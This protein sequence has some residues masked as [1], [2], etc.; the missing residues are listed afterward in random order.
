[1]IQ[2]KFDSKINNIFHFK[3]ISMKHLFFFLVLLIGICGFKTVPSTV[4]MPS[5]K[6]YIATV[7]MKVSELTLLHSE[8]EITSDESYTE[9]KALSDANLKQACNTPSNG[10]LVTIKKGTTILYQGNTR[11]YEMKRRG[12]LDF[13]VNCD[14][15]APNSFSEYG[16][17]DL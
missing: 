4:R 11:I 17:Y 16:F 3:I 12:F 10:Q 2:L 6:H 8:S 14:V 1:V 15:Y 5:E 7:P 13:V 9:I